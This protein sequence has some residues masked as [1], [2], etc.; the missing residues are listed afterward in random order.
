MSKDYFRGR[1]RRSVRVRGD[2]DMKE[3]FVDYSIEDLEIVEEIETESESENV[4]KSKSYRD[5]DESDLIESALILEDVFNA[6]LNK[7]W[8]VLGRTDNKLIISEVSEH[9]IEDLDQIEILSIESEYFFDVIDRQNRFTS[10][11]I[12]KKVGKVRNSKDYYF[13]AEEV[14]VE[15]LKLKLKGNK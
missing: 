15:N 7:N 8:Q 3:K 4:V 14:K 12:S 11:S 10:E 2:L 13:L 1:R 6:L 9:Q 5:Y